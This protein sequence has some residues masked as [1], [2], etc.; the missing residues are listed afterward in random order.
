[1]N[2]RARRRDLRTGLAIGAACCAVGAAAVAAPALAADPA[3]NNGTVKVDA[4]PFDTAPD[5]QPHVGCQFQID[6][7]GFDRGPYNAK[8]TF[9]GQAPTGPGV[10]LS[11]ST[12]FIGQ[13]AAGGGTDL[14]A[15]RTYDLS[16]VISKLGAP[17]PQQGYH[18][19]LTVNA[20]GSQGADTKYKVF[21]VSGCS[22]TTPPP[23][24]PSPSP[25]GS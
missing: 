22:T 18:V 2:E 23:P 12:V 8:V 11:T 6:F 24:S 3:G 13:D 5:N 9:T 20:P 10:V 14:D 17:Q 7:Y 1:M 15:Q 16:S 4:K 21:W 25:Y 19:K